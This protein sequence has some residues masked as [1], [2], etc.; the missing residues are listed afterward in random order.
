MLARSAPVTATLLAANVAL[1]GLERVAYAE[2]HD[3]CR[4]Y[5]LVPAHF[6]PSAIVTSMFL[7]DPSTLLHVA[8][9][10]AALGFFGGRVE[11]VL[12]HARFALLYVA[13]GVGGALLHVLVN[14]GA[15]E[16]M[17]GA[18]GAIWG[19]LA[20]AAVI[21]GRATLA[22]VATLFVENLWYAFF[23]G[24][25][26]IAFGAHIGGF[27]VGFLVLQ[28]VFELRWLGGIRPS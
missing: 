27:V 17:V 19:V 26:G 15:T 2:G 20:A 8:G 18:S 1:Y 10:V 22:F 6:E 24:G 7:H 21:Y 28:M 9:N 3:P 5:G 23:G 25:E 16:P 11:R 12:G 13:S 4:V 14:P